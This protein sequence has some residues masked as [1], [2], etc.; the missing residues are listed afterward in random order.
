Y[1][2]KNMA[3]YPQWHDETHRPHK[4]VI[5]T[6]ATEPMGKATSYFYA[7]RQCRVIMACREM[8]KCLSFRR[9]LVVDTK[10]KSI[11]CRHLDLEDVGS[12]NKFADQIIEKEPHVDVLVNNGFVFDESGEKMSNTH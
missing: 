1:P 11:V 5:V 6:G 12:I 7:T 2:M 8:D 4:T 10:N 3:L 9:E